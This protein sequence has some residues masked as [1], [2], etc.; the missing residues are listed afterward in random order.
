MFE[1]CGCVFFKN[2]LFEL[3]FINEYVIHEYHNTDVSEVQ[4][5][6]II[7]PTPDKNPRTFH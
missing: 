1:N 4:A 7:G 2:L 3:I 6:L 5:C